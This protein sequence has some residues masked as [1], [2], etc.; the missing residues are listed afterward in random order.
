MENMTTEVTES[1]GPNRPM[2]PDTTP[3]DYQHDFDKEETCNRCGAL[4]FTKGKLC[5]GQL[6][7]T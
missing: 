1:A 3:S 7:Q 6:S 4:G 5:T 2:H